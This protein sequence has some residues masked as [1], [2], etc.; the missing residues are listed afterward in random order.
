M[1]TST[2]L[3]HYQTLALDKFHHFTDVTSQ[4]I[5]EIEDLPPNAI[6]HDYD[7]MQLCLRKVPV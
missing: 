6:P 4:T 1:P 5:L 2:E 7:W 3:L